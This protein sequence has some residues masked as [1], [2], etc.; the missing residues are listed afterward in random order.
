M[1]KQYLDRMPRRLY[2]TLVNFIK[3]I[4]YLLS[5]LAGMAVLAAIAFYTK[6]WFDTPVPFFIICAISAMGIVSYKTSEWDVE[7][8]RRQQEKV[9]QA[10]KKDWE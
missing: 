7:K 3:M 8:E 2:W 4:G 5:V 9:E 1:F 6:Q 10:L